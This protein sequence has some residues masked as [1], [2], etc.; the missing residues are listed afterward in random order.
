MQIVIL[1]TME[2]LVAK[3]ATTEAVKLGDKYFEAFPDMNFP[4]FYQ[5]FLM[6]QPYFQTREFERASPV[7]EQLAI[8][9]ADKLD[10]IQS[11]SPENVTT[12]YRDDQV[13]A[14]AIARGLIQNIRLSGNTELQAMV[15]RI[16]GNYLYLA[17]G[18]P[19]NPG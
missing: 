6:L 5:T 13:R 4:Y 14:E 12:S 10:F 15:E 3:G 11:L 1:R 17:P 7:I 16:L 8:N 18:Q 2:E 9:V 19:G